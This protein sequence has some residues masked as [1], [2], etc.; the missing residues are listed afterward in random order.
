MTD[1]G[2]WLDA[3]DLGQYTTAFVETVFG[4]HWL[5]FR[6]HETFLTPM[7]ERLRGESSP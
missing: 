3:S 4:L 7:T 2:Q 6:A 5:K 1:T